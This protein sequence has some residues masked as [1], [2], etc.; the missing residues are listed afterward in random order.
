MSTTGHALEK[1]G[2]RISPTPL[3]LSGF[4]FSYLRC[5]LMCCLLLHLIHTSS[6]K[7]ICIIL[8]L[9]RLSDHR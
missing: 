3:H 5:F 2:R 8:I 7:C 4:I 6:L 9:L 1:K